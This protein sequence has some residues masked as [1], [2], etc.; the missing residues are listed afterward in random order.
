MILKRYNPETQ[1]IEKWQV[2]DEW[3]VTTISNPAL[4][5]RCARCGNKIRERGK[6]ASLAIMDEHGFSYMVCGACHQLEMENRTKAGV[7]PW[8][9]R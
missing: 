7:R 9:I 3:Q 5:T 1:R 2:P 6:Y 4:R 8:R